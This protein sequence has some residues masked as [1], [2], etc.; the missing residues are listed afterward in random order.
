MTVVVNTLLSKEKQY[1]DGINKDDSAILNMCFTFDFVQVGV[2]LCVRIN[3][4][5]SGGCFRSIQR[6]KR[7]VLTMITYRK[8]KKISVIL[9]LLSYCCAFWA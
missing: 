8:Y 1:H 7:H 6:E 9:R 5:F 3:Y 4:H 2:F